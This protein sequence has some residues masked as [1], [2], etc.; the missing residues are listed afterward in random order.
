MCNNRTDLVF[1]SNPFDDSAL[2]G[3][4]P[5]NEFVANFG[6]ESFFIFD[7]ETQANQTVVHYYM[8][9]E[10]DLRSM[11]AGGALNESVFF[12][13]RTTLNEQEFRLTFHKDLEFLEVLA[14]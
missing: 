6:C 3:R 11:S 10:L 8:E 2:T 9:K 4:P 1:R 12:L 5:V 14:T 13:N 7:E